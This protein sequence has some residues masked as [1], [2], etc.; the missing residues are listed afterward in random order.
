VFY[1]VFAFEQVLEGRAIDA[2][3]ALIGAW[4]RTAWA[5]GRVA[6]PTLFVAAALVGWLVPILLSLGGGNDFATV[7]A[8]TVI[9]TLFMVP[10]WTE[11]AVALPLIEKGLTGP[12]AALL[13]ALPAVSLPSLVI[14]GAAELA[15]PGAHGG[16]RLPQ[17][18]HRQRTLSVTGSLVLEATSGRRTSCQARP[19]A[20]PL[21]PRSSPF[22]NIPPVLE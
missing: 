21:T 2:P 7:L 16:R 10:T 4:L 20:A 18:R 11:I 14:F 22:D 13:L 5:I 6:V 9:G 8:A 3:A 19:P 12:A 1:R 15:D 17:R